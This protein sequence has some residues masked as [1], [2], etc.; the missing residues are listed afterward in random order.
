M[1]R[2]EASNSTG[3][4][5]RVKTTAAAN[6]IMPAR[7]RFLL[8]KINPRMMRKGAKREPILATGYMVV[9]KTNGW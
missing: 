6:K 1:A 7:I 5:I 8:V 2:L 4:V 9:R 3:K